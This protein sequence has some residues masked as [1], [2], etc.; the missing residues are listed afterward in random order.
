[1]LRASVFVIA[2]CDA[3]IWLL[4][5]RDALF[6]P[7]GFPISDRLTIFFAGIATLLVA[8]LV[9]PALIL[10]LKRSYLGLALGLAVVPLVIMV[11]TF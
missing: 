9:L 3:G 7:T 11:V 5:L 1:M 2:G 6:N 10:A 8:V 4:H